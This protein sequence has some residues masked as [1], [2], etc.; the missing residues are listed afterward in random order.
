MYQQFNIGSNV[1][2]E[3]TKLEFLTDSKLINKNTSKE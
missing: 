1:W 3:T 2:L